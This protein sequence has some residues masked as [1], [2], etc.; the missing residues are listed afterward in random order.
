MSNLEMGGT[1]GVDKQL[2][3][4]QK[5]IE[6]HQEKVNDYKLKFLKSIHR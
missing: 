1:F 4:K 5:S 6:K 2:E 3:I